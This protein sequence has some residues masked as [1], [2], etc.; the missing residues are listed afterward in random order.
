MEKSNEQITSVND[1]TTKNPNTSKT[2]LSWDVGIK[3]LAYCLL[4][5][6]YSD[7]TFKILK[8][9]VIN[10]NEGQQKCDFE[11]RTGNSC[12]ENAKYCIYHKDKIQLFQNNREDGCM[13]SCSKHK[14]KLIP[15]VKIIKEIEQKPKK[16]SAEIK[17]QC[18]SDKFCVICREKSTTELCGTIFCWCD[19]H[20]EKKGK[21]FVKKV[22]ARR[23]TTISC[24]KQPIQDLAEKLYTKLDNDFKDLGEISEILIE[25]QPTLKNPKMKTLSSI[26]YSYFILRGIVDK[27]VSGSKIS[28]VKFISPS[29]KLKVNSQNTNSLLTN[30]KS[31]TNSNVYKLTKSLGVKYCRALISDEDN[32]VI[33]KIKKKDDMCDAFLQG[34]QYLFTPVPEKYF[35]KLE[36]IG[37]SETDNTTK[38]K[39]INQSTD[40]CSED[41]NSDYNNDSTNNCSDSED[42]KP[43]KVKKVKKTKKVPKKSKNKKDLKSTS[44]DSENEKP[45]KAKNKKNV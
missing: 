38:T 5:K 32:S 35:K 26:L 29:N 37:F 2:I 45:K 4:Q 24:N 44:S 28:E 36:K 9:G 7:D 18:E 22:G 25:N 16:K 19:E 31:K 6:D 40:D 34:F 20:Y 23:Y 15:E 13:Y 41:D 8:W 3:N 11:L 10:L 30:E 12:Q 17:T 14:E 21:S 42:E 1:D 33:E 39:K 43:K 27:N